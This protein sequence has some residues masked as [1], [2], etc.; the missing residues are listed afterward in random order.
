MGSPGDWPSRDT[1]RLVAQQYE[2]DIKLASRKSIGD[3]LEAEKMRHAREL[4]VPNERRP[5][6]KEI[7]VHGEHRWTKTRAVEFKIPCRMILQE[8]NEW[9]QRLLFRGST[10]DRL[11]ICKVSEA[12]EST[13]RKR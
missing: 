7:P 10:G 4:H 8:L 12:Q 13:R 6:T 9:P 2:S 5:V 11:A 3:E 1:E